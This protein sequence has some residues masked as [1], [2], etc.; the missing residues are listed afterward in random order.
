MDFDHD[1]RMALTK[2]DKSRKGTVDA[3]IRALCDIINNKENYYTTSSCS[4]RIQLL[5]IAPSRKKHETK[6]LYSTHDRADAK[7][8]IKTLHE[9]DGEVWLRTECF[10]LHVVCRTIR[11]ADSLLRA[12]HQLGLKRAGIISMGPKLT[13]EIINHPRIDAPLRTEGNI[14][15]QDHYIKF[16]TELGNTLLDKNRDMIARLE[17]KIVL[18]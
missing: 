6:F 18:L 9:S 13:I 8:V 11:D 10:I 12:C 4:G 3:G 2:K 16:L 17:K 14:L 5:W 1:K 7:E 15:V